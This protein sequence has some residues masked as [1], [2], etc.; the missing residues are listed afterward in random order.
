MASSAPKVAAREFLRELVG[1]LAQHVQSPIDRVG[2]RLISVGRLPRAF[3]L[4]LFRDEGDLPRIA[5]ALTRAYLPDASLR[6]L[7]AS[8]S[9]ASPA[10]EGAAK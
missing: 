6:D 7:V 2:R 10:T 4:L 3:E 9:A 8:A 5:V 1:P